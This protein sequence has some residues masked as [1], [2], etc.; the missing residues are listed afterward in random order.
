M[1]KVAILLA[2]YNGSKYL[3]Q[4]LVSVFEQANVEI[5]IFVS[6]DCSKD[7]TSEILET[8]AVKYGSITFLSRNEVFGS[9]AKNFFFLC[10][11][12]DI[13]RFN[14]VAFCDQ[15]DI[16]LPSKLNNA[17]Q[18]LRSKNAM[19]YSS[20]C[21]AFWNSRDNMKLVR[22]SFN[23]TNV[24]YWFESPGP[25]CTQ[26]FTADFFKKFQSF[27]VNNWVGIQSV[28]Y[29]DWLSYA[30][31]RSQKMKWI[32]SSNADLLYRQ[33][34]NNQIGSNSG[35]LQ[36]LKRF[37][38]MKSRWYRKQID[39]IHYLCTGDRHSILNYKFMTGNILQLRRRKSHSLFLWLMFSVGLI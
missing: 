4:L 21:I 27:I 7:N 15:D 1:E 24:D 17:V 6:D 34:A 20:D 3:Q 10:R 26:V 30:F 33:H 28:D 29:H 23:Q 38:M 9:A 32:I 16:W 5:H 36:A 39:T 12:V 13:T 31:A 35:M 25:G 8:F 19:A 14:Y 18:E 2:T 11:S 22:K 37:R